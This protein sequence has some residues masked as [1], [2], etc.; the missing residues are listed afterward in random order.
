MIY[1]FLGRTGE[2]SGF[3]G[4]QLSS[5]GREKGTYLNLPTSGVHSLVLRNVD[6]IL[7]D[8]REDFDFDTLRQGVVG[9][10]NWFGKILFDASRTFSVK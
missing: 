7:C 4:D 1:L 5:G 10:G 2:D 8:L 6:G 9:L 3:K